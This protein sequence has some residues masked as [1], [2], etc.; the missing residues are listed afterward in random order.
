MFIENGNLKEK[1]NEF[2]WNSN[3][4][5]IQ[6]PRKKWFSNKNVRKQ[7]T[8]VKIAELCSEYQAQKWFLTSFGSKYN[9]EY[10]LDGCRARWLTQDWCAAIQTIDHGQKNERVWRCEIILLNNQSSQKKLKTQ[11]WQERQWQ[12]AFKLTMLI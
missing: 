3:S 2:W 9:Q 7:I 4:D 10:N 1:K 11:F 12:L 6:I 5:V 8:I